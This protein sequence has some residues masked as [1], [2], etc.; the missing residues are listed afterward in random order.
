MNKEDRN[1]VIEST[2]KALVSFIP[3]IGGAIGSILSDALAD[4][5]EQRL[6][7]F[8]ESLK[9]QV[10]SNQ[11]MV[12]HDFIKKVDFL[13][14]FE[15]TATRIR[16]ERAV[17]KRIA[18][19]NI[20]L[21]G[22]FSSNCTYDEIET[23]IRILDQLFPDHLVLLRLFHSPTNFLTETTSNLVGGSFGNIFRKLFPNWE[24][25]YLVD[26]LFELESLRLIESLSPNLK[27]MMVGVSVQSLEGKLT[28]RG[29]TFVKF[30]LA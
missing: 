6:K 24:W 22:I 30:V 14:I 27:T 15:K 21:H 7:E 28:S 17:E 12:N 3:G 23:Q 8:L 13:D 2:T 5:K 19:K 9:Q 25:D 29:K 1:Y 26:S 20:L 4:R 11:D 18:Y 10:E 16:D